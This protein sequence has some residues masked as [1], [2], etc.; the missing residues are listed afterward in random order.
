[1]LPNAYYS[2]DATNQR[3][4]LENVAQACR[5]CFL[6]LTTVLSGEIHF[7]ASRG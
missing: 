5:A 7:G 2:K 6:T 1:M 4:F 3:G